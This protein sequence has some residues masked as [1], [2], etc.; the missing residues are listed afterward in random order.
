M[1]TVSTVGT[2]SF[3]SLV[4]TTSNKP[5]TNC[6]DINQK[7]ITT[8]WPSCLPT[9]CYTKINFNFQFCKSYFSS[10]HPIWVFFPEKVYLIK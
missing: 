8:E 3:S 5:A 9:L 6:K 2:L 10:K 1:I 4:Y 7:F